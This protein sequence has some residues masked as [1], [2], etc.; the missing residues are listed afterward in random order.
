MAQL[1]NF[2]LANFMTSLKDGARP[3]QF[4]VDIDI[5][6]ALVGAI[7]DA[8]IA[9]N[10]FRFHCKATS[11]PASEVGEIPIS[12]RGKKFK[13]AGDKTFEDWTVTIINDSDFILRD[14]FEQWNEAI[15]GNVNGDRLVDNV[16]D[17]M[18]TGRIYQLDQNGNILAAYDFIGAWPAI[19]GAV[20]LSMDTSDTVE[21]FDVTFKYQWFEGAKTRNAT[22]SDASI[23]IGGSINIAI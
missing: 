13:I 22:N 14:A 1:S 20:Q 2:T 16:I 10:K 12:F 15:V 19:V 23:S 3:N 5:P 6:P 11:L 18:S 21:E 7:P 9:E 8:L 4:A 17:Y